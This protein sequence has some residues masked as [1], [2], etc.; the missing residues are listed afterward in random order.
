MSNEYPM[1]KPHLHAELIK[2]WADGAVIQARQDYNYSW[3]TPIPFNL[4][5]STTYRTDPTCDYAKAK[6]AELG[7]DDMVELYLHW[8]D[9]GELISHFCKSQHYTPQPYKDP[10]KEFIHILENYDDITKKKRMVKQV[11][12]IGRCIYASPTN[13]IETWVD[14]SI[15]VEAEEWSKFMKTGSKKYI[16]HKVP[17]CTRDV[18]E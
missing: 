17:S 4:F 8:L 11:L 6:I 7:G 14:E 12:W 3:Y 1:P 15:D 5:K 10:F 18:E 2:A 16:W 9:G 13:T